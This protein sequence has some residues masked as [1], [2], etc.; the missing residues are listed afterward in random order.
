MRELERRIGKLESEK[1][2]EEDFQLVVVD[3]EL[4]D[5]TRLHNGVQVVL[6]PTDYSPIIHRRARR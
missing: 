2:V 4:P 3:E 6:K 1:S 5:G